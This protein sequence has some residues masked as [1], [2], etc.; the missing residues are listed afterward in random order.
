MVITRVFFDDS[1]N[2][3]DKW[4]E[5][6]KKVKIPILFSAGNHKCYYDKEDVVK[7]LNKTKI[8]YLNKDVYEL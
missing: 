7:M 4:L 5:P 8:I 1:L 3:K 2:I 6:F